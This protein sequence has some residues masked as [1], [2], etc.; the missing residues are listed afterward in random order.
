VGE[1]VANDIERFRGALERPEGG[2]D[3]LGFSELRH[4]DLESECALYLIY[5]KRGAG[6]VGVAHNCQ[7]AEAGDNLMQEFEALASRRQVLR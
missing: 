1:R 2:R 3:I 7:A 4:C 6:I 5:L